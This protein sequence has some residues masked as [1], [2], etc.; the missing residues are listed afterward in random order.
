MIQ[1]KYFKEDLYNILGV[2]PLSDT[3]E[4]RSKYRQ[5]ALK[6][7]PDKG[8][9]SESF[10]L[11][12]YAFEVLSCYSSRLMYDRIK[13][14]KVQ[15]QSKIPCANA[16]TTEQS[17]KILRR[18]AASVLH[19][20]KRGVK[21]PTR[22]WSAMD[23]PAKYQSTHRDPCSLQERLAR[24]SPT[25]SQLCAILQEMEPGLRYTSI[26]ALSP[27]LRVSLAAFMKSRR[28]SSN[29]NDVGQNR[30]KQTD[31][32]T[33]QEH[34]FAFMVSKAL[35]ACAT[36]HRPTYKAHLHI[37]AL[38]FYTLAHPNLEV[39]LDRQMI[40]MQ[41]RQALVAATKTHSC[42]WEDAHATYQ[43]CMEVLNANRTSEI[44]MGLCSYVYLRAANLLVQTR[45]IIS[46]VIPLRETLELHS[47]LLRARRT[48]WQA[49]R[50][51]W[52]DIM[53]STRQPLAKRKT[54]VDAEVIADE[55]RSEAL[56]I[57]FTRLARRLAKSVEHDEKRASRQH[58]KMIQHLR[59]EQ[60]KIVTARK[61]ALA[62][63]RQ[64]RREDEA[65]HKWRQEWMKRSDLTMDDIMGGPPAMYR[66]GGRN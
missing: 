28:A 34:Q 53:L 41:L 16:M 32:S 7:H 40:L 45:T 50:A 61:L 60:R 25:L 8:G 37:K 31:K 10:H 65:Q 63:R 5:A 39:A 26:E 3:A 59:K 20:A 1:S 55:A 36:T 46:P 15:N 2:H 47:R 17:K 21:R 42:L 27:R 62:S 24:L 51:E 44:D 38:R 12:T 35:H 58:R 11:L 23:P 57:Q 54:L 9:S 30:K 6:A 14:L 33:Q 13:E 18:M 56:K 43:I 52:I 22:E 4:I 66:K 48:S 49:L 29:N 64:L 19:L